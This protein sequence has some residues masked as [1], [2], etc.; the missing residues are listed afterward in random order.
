M[1]R[2]ARKRLTWKDDRPFLEVGYKMELS[3]KT[4]LSA[5]RKIDKETYRL[6]RR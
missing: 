6:G 3:S 5:G 1:R 2:G 4:L